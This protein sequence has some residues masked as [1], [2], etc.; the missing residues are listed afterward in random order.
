MRLLCFVNCSIISVIGRDRKKMYRSYRERH[1]QHRQTHLSGMA[2]EIW[3]SN[4]V[5]RIME[6]GHLMK[7]DGVNKLCISH[8][9]PHGH[10]Y[11]SASTKMTGI[12]ALRN[13]H[14]YK[15]TYPVQ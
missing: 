7:V 14:I 5:N 1:L 3:A 10:G 11:R 8:E 2:G 4:A 15:V 13:P 9:N 12:S 6:N